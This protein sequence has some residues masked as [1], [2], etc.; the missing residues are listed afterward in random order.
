[1]IMFVIPTAMCESFLSSVTFEDI[2][3]S[4]HLWCLGPCKTIH[5]LIYVNFDKIISL[6]HSE[7]IKMLFRGLLHKTLKYMY[8]C[9]CSHT[10]T[11]QYSISSN[12]NF[13]AN[14]MDL[15]RG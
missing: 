1:M 10:N 15:Y 6:W 13:S 8:G 7:R 5:G 14:K 2:L 3:K 12:H 11:G 4:S 9:S